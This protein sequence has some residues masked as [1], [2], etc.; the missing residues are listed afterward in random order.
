[1]LNKHLIAQTRPVADPANIFKWKDMRITLLADALFRIE[2]SETMR[3]CDH[4]TQIVWFRDA[5]EIRKTVELSETAC[6]V[7]TAAAELHLAASLEDSYILLADGRRAALSNEGNLKGTY[8]T[9]DACDGNLC[10]PDWN[11]EGIT[12]PIELGDGVLSRTG[13]AVL[14]DSKSLLLKED[15]T[16]APRETKEIDLYVF[17]FGCSYRRAIQA[18]YRI[19][20]APPVIPR[21]ALGNWWSRYWAYTQQEYL[22][23]MDAFTDQGLPFTVA[24]VDMDWHPSKNLP[25]GESG[26][27]GYSWNTELFPDYRAFLRELHERGLHVTLNLHPALG[28]RWFEVQYEAMARRMGVDPA[29]RET[30]PFNLVSTDF[31]NAY[32]DVLHKPY[33]RDGVDFWW[34]DWQQGTETGVEGL[35][36]LWML[37]HYHSLDIAKEKEQLI[38]SRFSGIGSHRYPLGFSGDTFMTWKSL[39][40]LISFTARASNAGYSWWSHDIGGHTNGYKDHE[41]FV[42]FVQFGVFSP[43]NRLHS[44]NSPVLAKEIVSYCGGTGLIAREYLRLRHAMLPF[45][46]T[47]DCETAEQG[48]ALIEPMYYQYPHVPEAY[49]CDAQYLFGRQMIAAPITQR[50]GENGLT[51]QRVWL[52]EGVWTDFFTGDAYQGGRWVVLHRPLDTFPLLCKEGGF[53][54]LDGSHAG[55]STALPAVLDVH[56]F[57]GNGAY[58]LLEDEGDKRAKTFFTS[59]KTGENQHTLT[60]RAED[61]EHILP[62]RSLRLRFRNVL[63]GTVQVLQNGVPVSAPVRQYSN[64]TIVTLTGWRPDDVCTV[65]VT[66]HA[67]M[68]VRYREAM[69]RVMKE[70]EGD[71]MMRKDLLKELLQCNE[72]EAFRRIIAESQLSGGW[73]ARLLEILEFA[74][75]PFDRES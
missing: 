1:M 71:N 45:L 37:N 32:F 65:T 17:A 70:T 56:T 10:Y 6:I 29:S 26:W 35:D 41:L 47:A 57:A 55:N 33:E 48:L 53:F 5:D 18:L 39:E 25:G 75:L 49:A 31:L 62:V 46:Y 20:G 14:D 63:Q 64:Y 42:R 40:H 22:D 61:P 69:T 66:E 43:I 16:I 58:T 13:V 7:K 50:T 59:E 38:L 27:T 8:R 11:E 21:Y 68:H 67:D 52:P 44:T 24:T 2:K 72:S 9:L 74:G 54:V 4:A 23:L 19:S 15:G 12:Y 34:V 28:V 3:F 51:A 60:I 36:P 73:K 30:I